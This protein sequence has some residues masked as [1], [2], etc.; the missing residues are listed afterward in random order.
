MKK[1]KQHYIVYVAVLIFILSFKNN[2]MA[3]ASYFS[4]PQEAVRIT[5]KLLIE[6][7][8]KILTSYYYLENS[9][10]KL[11]DSLKNGSY[12]IRTKK[13]EISHPGVSWKY[14]K[15]FPP[16]FSYYTHLPIDKYKVK[17][18]VQIEIDQGNGMIQK[19]KSFFYLRKSERGFQILPILDE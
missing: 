1:Q 15:P 9:S 5:S 14:K 16:S 11:L 3:Q 4:S 7:N 19:G 10:P 18:E 13:P 2:L 6:E 17:V 12:F 8:W